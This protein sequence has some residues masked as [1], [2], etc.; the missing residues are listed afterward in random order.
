MYKLIFSLLLVIVPAA[1]SQEKIHVETLCDACSLTRTHASGDIL[2]ISVPNA[3]LYSALFA[4]V[5]TVFYT[6]FSLCF[7][8]LQEVALDRSN[9]Q[10]RVSNARNGKENQ[11][12]SH[13]ETGF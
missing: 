12:P 8:T 5:L 13:Y 10:H 11:S 4:G 6:T 7:P 3:Y 2:N 1:F 9:K